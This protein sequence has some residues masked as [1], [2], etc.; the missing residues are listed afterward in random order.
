MIASHPS[1]QRNVFP[2][3]RR[4]APRRE[5]QI[6]ARLHLTVSP[7]EVKTLDVMLP[8]PK[9]IGYTRNISETGLALIVPS[10]RIG[11]QYLNTVNC[12]LQIMLELPTGEVRI[13]ATPVRYEQ[14]VEPKAKRGYLIGVRIKEMS[15]NEWVQLV[16]Y[17]RSLH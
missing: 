2:L 10:I 1:W 7:L 6:E 9:I 13:R 11:D 4:G 12:S 16:Q 5:V 17:I 14:I 8:S 15:D 3:E